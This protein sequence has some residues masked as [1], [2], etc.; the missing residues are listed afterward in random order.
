LFCAICAYLEGGQ[1]ERPVAE[2]VAS[3]MVGLERALNA[4]R[5]HLVWSEQ[6]AIDD[7]RYLQK[8]V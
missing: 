1:C 6:C 5:E 4:A 2:Y 8:G 7:A 3:I